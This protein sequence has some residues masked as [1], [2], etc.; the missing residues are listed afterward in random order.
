VCHHQPATFY[1]FKETVIF[2]GWCHHELGSWIWRALGR[3]SRH[4][5]TTW[6]YAHSLLIF[7]SALDIVTEGKPGAYSYNAVC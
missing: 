6:D 3:L 7:K 4:P 1:F 2:A 5:N